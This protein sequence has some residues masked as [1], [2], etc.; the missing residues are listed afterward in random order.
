MKA[1]FLKELKSYL[2][3]TN[4]IAFLSLFLFAFGFFFSKDCLLAG[5]NRLPA[6]CSDMSYAL[7]L[8]TPLLTVGMFPQERKNNTWGIMLSYPVTLTQTVL[9][10]YFAAMAVCVACVAFTWVYALVLL[11][12][13]NVFIGEFIMNQ[14]GLTF[15]LAAYV[16]TG[17]AVSSFSRRRLSAAAITVSAL[18]IMFLVSKSSS[19]IS[20]ETISGFL[21][22]IS[23]YSAYSGIPSGTLRLSG[24]AYLIMYSALCIVIPVRNV[25]YERS[26]GI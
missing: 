20:E 3:G 16:A 17:E 5:T 6:V 11:I 8:L 15:L 10:K 21:K 2:S 18:F 26:R 19:F 23:P 12:F 14:I 4:S 22:L 7:I 1:I 25:E 9:A 24:A 13:T